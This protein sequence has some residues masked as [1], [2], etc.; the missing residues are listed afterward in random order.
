MRR[1]PLRY[2]VAGGALVVAL[3]AV[4][5]LVAQGLGIGQPSTETGLVIDV[6]S[7]SAVDIT[8]FT[9]RTQ[10]G[11]IQ[12]YAVGRLDT[13]SPAFPAVHLRSHLISL[14]PVVVTYEMDGDQ[15][16]ALRIVDAVLPAST[17][18]PLAATTT[19]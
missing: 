2:V 15:R 12:Q 9:L 11:R 1:L 16:V 10:D 14:I 17:A 7:T 3:A 13:A 18:T 5:L 4:A 19:P 8:G 6:Q